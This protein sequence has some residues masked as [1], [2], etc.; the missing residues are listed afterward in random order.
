MEKT[1]I[2]GP[3]SIDLSGI[4]LEG[5][6]LD[7]GGGGEGVIS[8]FKNRQVVAIDLHESELKEVLENDALQIIMDAKELKFLDNSFNTVT[9]FF[10]LLYA[11]IMEHEKIFQEIYRVLKDGG[12]FV[13]WDVVIPKRGDNAKEMFV[14]EL[15][16][17][18]LNKIIKTGYG[19]LWNKEQDL[20]YYSS[21]AKSIGFQLLEQEINNEIFNIRFKKAL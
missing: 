3:F 21:L 12:E 9:A 6:I 19:T 11:P 17:K 15:E 16:I 2:V 1:F 7:I 18:I 8:Q 13:L 14:V 5:R 4:T 10:T 20:S